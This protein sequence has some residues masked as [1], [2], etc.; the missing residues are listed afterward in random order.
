MDE[1][2]TAEINHFNLTARVG[3]DQYVLWLE[4]AVNQLKVMDEGECVKDLL[5]DSLESW[6]VEIEL[7]FNLTVVLGVLIQ[8]VTKELSHY[9]KMLFV[10]EEIDQLKQVLVVEVF[11]VCVDVSKE[12]DFINGLIEVILVILNDFHANHL[13]RMD[14][15]TLD[16]FRKGCATKIFDYL[17]PACDDAID[18]DWE[19]FGLFETSLF[20]IKYYSQVIAVIDNA[21]ELSR[22]ELVI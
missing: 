16:S 2:A 7:L 3:L 11:T 21:I 13:L 20:T 1:A 18:D 5:S 14:V 8:V 15:I 4:I 17:V 9:E 22:V 10:V 12:F 19:V 6:H